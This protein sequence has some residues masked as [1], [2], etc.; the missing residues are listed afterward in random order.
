MSKIIQTLLDE[1]A[2]LPPSE[3]KVKGQTKPKVAFVV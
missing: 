3:A 2:K 1:A